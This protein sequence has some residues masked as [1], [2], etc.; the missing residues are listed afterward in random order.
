MPILLPILLPTLMLP[1]D[2]ELLFQDSTRLPDLQYQLELFQQKQQKLQHQQPQQQQQQSLR[3]PSLQL[4]PMQ[5]SWGLPQAMGSWMPSQ[6]ALESLGLMQANSLPPFRVASHLPHEI[7]MQ[8]S[9]PLT[10]IGLV[11]L[12]MI[13]MPGGATQPTEGCL[14]PAVSTGIDLIPVPQLAIPAIGS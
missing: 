7:S 5:E 6:Q 8:L 1:G 13:L 2:L 10:S 9:Q 3:G 14:S 12:S 11:P 4:L